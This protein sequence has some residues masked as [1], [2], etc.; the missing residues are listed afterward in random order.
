MT[1]AAA[2]P[3]PILS[4]GI[5][6][7]AVAWPTPKPN[8][9]AAPLPSTSIKGGSAQLVESP[10]ETAETADSTPAP[11]MEPA[12]RQDADAEP[13]AEPSPPKPQWLTWP[14]AHAEQLRT[15]RPVLVLVSFEG[16]APCERLK[17][18]LSKPE[19]LARF[20]EL[21]V[22]CLG[23]ARDWQG[24]DKTEWQA[25]A[26]VYADGRDKPPM[27]TKLKFATADQFLES[28]TGWINAID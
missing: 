17:K 24:K 9:P 2:S 23:H 10:I 20:A 14:E 22:P 16:C 4:A 21:G 3:W 18:L 13:P 6:A 12:P 26:I 19:T 27:N 11:R 1:N 28:L 7:L 8:T 5:V 25:P 15:G